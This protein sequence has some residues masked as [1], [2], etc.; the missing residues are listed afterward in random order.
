MTPSPARKIGLQLL[1]FLLIL[2][3][4]AA[5]W[6]MRNLSE[7]RAGAVQKAEA[8]TQNL[9]SVLDQN[10]TGSVEKIDLALQN[11]ADELQRQHRE[12]GRLDEQQV[13]RMLDTY[14]Q[15]MK[16]LVAIRVSNADG[17][18]VLGPDVRPDKPQSWADRP[19]FAPLRD[20]PASG[21]Y[22]TQ[23]ITGRVS[24]IEVISF[25]RRINLPDG[26]F[27]GLISA[28]IPL[29]HF[30]KLLAGLDLGRSGV[31]ALRGADFGLIAR[32][33]PSPVAA[34]GTVGSQVIPPELARAKSRAFR[35]DAPPAHS[36]TH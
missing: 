18:V 24:G 14:Q 35:R 20:Q 25:V 8:T 21:L 12:N 32:Q 19:F 17:Q 36:E 23:P 3:S 5:L 7:Q 15:R 11:V 9:A 29:S 6:V 4:A 2:N 30:N 22:I 13:S 10:I 26:Q 1:A 33:P 16:G 31:A 27:G 28:A 34:A